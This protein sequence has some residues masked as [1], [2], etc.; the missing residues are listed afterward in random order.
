LWPA[1]VDGGRNTSPRFPINAA[2]ESS[3]PVVAAPVVDVVVVDD[4]DSEDFARTGVCG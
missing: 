1:T 2:D 3:T 4:D